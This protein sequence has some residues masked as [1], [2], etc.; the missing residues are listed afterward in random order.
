MCKNIV[1]LV[2]YI[3]KE[4]S[5]NSIVTACPTS[6]RYTI[7]TYDCNKRKI[8]RFRKTLTKQNRTINIKS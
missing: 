6:R 1:H 5:L 3:S 7:N 8:A 2:K 4:S